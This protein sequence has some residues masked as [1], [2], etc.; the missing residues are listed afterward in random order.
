MK[1][2]KLRGARTHN[3]KNIDIDIPRDKLVVITG[4][5]GSGKS[6]LAFDT[7]YAEGQ[8]RYVESLSAYARQFLSM[9]EKPDIDHIEGLSPAI[10]IEQKSTSHN[11]RSTVGTITEIY[12]Y[13]RLLYARTGEP[14]CPEHNEPLAAQ[15]VSQ[16]VDQILALGEGTK[17]MII[18]PLIRERKGEHLHVFEQLRAQGF[19]R[20]RVDGRIYELDELPD[21]EKNKK[22]TIEVV[23]DRIKVRDDIALRL[24][25]SIETSLAL[26]EGL[27]LAAF[28]DDED[29]NKPDLI[30]SARFACPVCNYSINELEPRVFSFNNPSGACPSCDGLGI[31]QFFDVDR[32]VQHPESTI[33]EGAIRGWDRRNL[34][35]FNMLTSLASHY[36]FDIDTPF[37]ALTAAQQQKVLFGSG[38]EEIAFNYV[39]DRGSVYKRTHTFEGIIPNMERRYRETESQT[40][41]E[42]LAKFQ[43]SQS[44]PECSGQRLNKAA[45]H[46]FID[47]KSL[48]E[49]TALSIGDLA[50]YYQQLTLEGQQAQIAEQI[51]K[52]IRDRLHFLVDVGLN[53]LTLDRSADT[54][55]GG[56]AQR[57][58]L[59]SQ[60]GA[61]LVGVMYIL[62]EP[63]IG[64]H[65][66]DNT[67]LL[68]TL[69]HLRDLGNTVIV[70]EHDE[71]AI[72]AADYVVDIGPGAGVHGGEVI[73]CGQVEDIL[74]EERSLTGDYLS[75]KKSIVIPAERTPNDADKQLSLRGVDGNNLQAVDIDIP[76][77]LLTCITGVSGSGKSTLIN[78][79]L[80]PLAATALNKATTLT[81]A[82]HTSVNGLDQL[83]KCVDIDQSPIGRTPRSNPATYTGIF[84]PV[85]ELF[86]GTQEARSRGYKAGRFSFNVKGGR[87]EACQGDGVKKVEMHFLPDVYVTCDTCKGARYN[88]ET[89]EIR[90]KGKNIHQ[91]LEMTIEDALEFFN[92]VP[93]IANKLQTLSD[94]GLSYIKLGQA[95]TTL[96][97]GEAQRVKLSREL[98]KRDT[99]KTL[100][101]LDEPTTGLHFHDIQQ[102]LTVLHRFR[103]HGNTVVVIEHNLD[104]VKTADWVIDLGPEGG[105]GGGRIIATGTPE[106]V[107]ATKGSHTGHFLKA[108][109]KPQKPESQAANQA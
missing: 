43:N 15:T 70:V 20:A 39:N 45:R 85:R 28:M 88:R 84:T 1:M 76:I 95:A 58:R 99:G 17:L 78:E 24:S 18:A 109:L 14:R 11:P 33:S 57:I 31:K 65:Q 73:A 2:I 19:I 67:R 51:L 56:E 27:V 72:R 9:M 89:L 60:I 92:P 96:S 98:S 62:D 12:D 90:Y 42:D 66:R 79:T 55:S 108:L 35:Y 87:C 86:A 23:V 47:E 37:E 77:G 102:L 21:L 81:A 107:A 93:S 7:L 97:G 54:L 80:Y 22:H 36:G 71:E 74:A 41:R 49:V 50:D 68:S 69:V 34:F 40:V 8:R 106:Q 105:S 3:L 82:P 10:S 29:K 6:S 59:A 100:Y 13:L 25:E 38:N 94:V 64:L 32:V 61:G 103:D 75:G 4:L 30:F 5:S 83:D 101:I 91:V 44:C 26:S 48:P 104:V 52:E 16:M 63:S 53:Y 46:V